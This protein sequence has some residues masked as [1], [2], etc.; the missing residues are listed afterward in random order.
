MIRNILYGTNPIV[1]HA[2]SHY[3]RQRHWPKIR[4]HFFNS[5]ER[6]LTA[7]SDVTIVTCNNGHSAMG[8]FEDSLAHFGLDCVVKGQGIENWINSE[9]K[10]PLILEA[11]AETTT[12]YLLYVDSRDAIL[13]DDPAILVERYEAHFRDY[14]MVFSSDLLS[15]PTVSEFTRFERQLPGAADTEFKYLNGGV[16]MGRTDFCREFWE[17]AVQTPPVE[18]RK[19]SEQGILRRVFQ[20]FVPRVTM[21]YRCSMFQNIGFVEKPIFEF[22]STG[23]NTL[24]EVEENEAVLQSADR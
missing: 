5:Q 15:W 11:A 23:R 10:P 2:H 4:E 19:D 12:P 3:P 9:H 8:L 7:C 20:E 6:S 24:D 21:D 18:N 16:W 1:F 17:R 22:L 14:D 13:M